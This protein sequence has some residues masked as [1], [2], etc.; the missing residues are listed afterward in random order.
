M[1]QGAVTRTIGERVRAARAA[2]NMTRKQLAEKASVSE[3]YL[4]ELE[5]GDANVSVG[6][7]GRVAEAL[8]VDLVSLLPGSRGVPKGGRA[9]AAM[10]AALARVVDGMSPREQE[11]A[12]P[13]LERFL[14]DHRKSL[15]GI[16][17]L[18]LRGAGK[19][20][21]GG[22]FAARH[23]LPFLSVTREIESRAG[24]SVNDLFNL[25]GPDAY[26]A[27][28]SEVIKE[29]SSRNDRIVLETAGGIVGSGPALDMI[30]GTFK[31]VWL[32]ASPEEHLKR[33]ISQGD[34]RPMHGMP[35][36]IEHLK[37]L[38]AKREQEYARADCVI[39]TTGRP[40]DA[41]VDELEMMTCGVVAAAR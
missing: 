36:A 16:A 17:L 32:R 1:E 40:P 39:D 14:H 4:N 21:I 11:S 5:N 6:I 38:L 34:M 22:M 24:M 12:A 10:H 3:R 33:V 25:G 41:C 2:A 28:E 30:L 23:G 8:G 29:L 20:T 9:D 26:R 35:G 7:L 15:Q 27:L 18:G 37:A 13:F 19:T 31:T